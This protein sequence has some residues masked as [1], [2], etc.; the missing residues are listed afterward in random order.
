MS[1]K[2]WVFAETDGAKF[3]DVVFELLEK[4][5]GMSAALSEPASVEAVLIG[6]GVASMAEQLAACGAQT[7]HVADDPRLKHWSPSTFVPVVADLA[8]RHRPDVFLFGATPV[9]GVLGPSVAV[10]LRTGMAAHAVDLRVEEDMS[11]V[12][13]VPAFGGRVVGEI[14]CPGT[15]PQMASV[16]PG[17]FASGSPSPAPCRV[18]AADLSSLEKTDPSALK[19]LGTHREIPSGVPLNR[20]QVVLCGGFGV[21]EREEWELLKEIA[22]RLGGAAACTRPVVDRGWAGEHL[23]VGTSGRSI[24]PKVYLGFGISGATHH[25]CGM[26]DSGLVVSVNRDSE[27]PMFE[28]SDVRVVADAGEVLR[29]LGRIVQKGE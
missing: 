18:A 24:R 25:L 15:R 8:A 9:G 14:L 2:I 10:R 28:V 13:S 12:A 16:K 1:G 27:A 4:A 17:I 29:A 7:V 11:L 6:E 19:P 21:D 20:A 22:K 5:V 3:P 26:C 23:M